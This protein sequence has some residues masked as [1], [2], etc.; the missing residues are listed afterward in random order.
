V[1]E[2]ALNVACSGAR[3]IGITNCLNF[4]SPEEP[5][6]YW[7]LSE[8][9]AGMADACRTLGIPIVS[10][11][12]SLYN[13]T[14]GGRI[15]PTPV[16]GTVGLIEDRSAMVPMTWQAGDEV[17]LLGELAPDAGS[18]AGSELAWQGG[19]FGGA[20]S[21]DVPAAARLVEL[22]GRMPASGLL[23][24]AH[25]L[26]VGGLGVALAR[27]AI[28]SAVGARVEVPAA[29]A[30]LPTAG[31]FGERGGRVLVSLRPASGSK[32]AAAA[33][34][35]GVAAQPIGHAGGDELRIGIGRGRLTVGLAGLREAWT[36]PF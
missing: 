14:P 29:M 28:A 18:L 24:G 12:V 10:G 26:S 11:N 3:P 8:A 22:L 20:P 15:L 32:L 34:S 19:R 35:A 7:Q 1:V 36:T 30:F 31:L 33:A 25:D 9:V 17:W 4:G 2:G 21:L 16:I 6:G 23:T 5:A 13:E 27:L